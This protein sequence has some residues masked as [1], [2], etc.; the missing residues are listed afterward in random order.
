MTVEISI[1][2]NNSNSNL[3]NVFDDD[4]NEDIFS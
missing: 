3:Y 1:T 2:R 4:I